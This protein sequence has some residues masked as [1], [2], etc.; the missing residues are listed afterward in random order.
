MPPLAERNLVHDKVRLAVTLTGIIFAVVLIVVQLGLFIGF[1]TTTSG[2]IDHAEADI[3]IGPKHVP[4]LEQASP[5]SERKLY[6]ALA[7]PGVQAAEKYIVRFSDWQRLDG[8]HEGIQVVGFNPDSGLGGPWNIVAGKL[9]DLKSPDAVFVDQFYRSKLGVTHLGQVFEIRGHRARVVGFTKGIRAFTTTPY[10]FTTFKNAQNYAG[11]NE[12]Q[13]LY[14]L[15][16]AE[17]GTDLQ[18][19]KH[20]LQEHVGEV[21]V[22]TAKEFSRMTRFY[23]MFSTGAGVAVL[24]AALLGLVVGVVV[25][26]QTIYATT[27]DH[28]REYGTLKAMGAPNR[29]VY[30]VIIKQAA[31]SAVIGYVLGMLV[32]IFVVHGSQKMGASILLPRPMALGMFVLTLLMCIVAAVVSINKVT[33]IDPAMVFKG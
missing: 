32:S 10:V 28:L 3:W 25:V 6:E 1:A 23:W 24:L 14:I 20:R 2:L 11:L 13:T 31:I 12:D 4:Y 18:T 26:A 21:D 29:Y 9:E 17:P 15:V 33:H 19:L 8:G 5:L 27:I 30:A 16:K 22:F 7:T